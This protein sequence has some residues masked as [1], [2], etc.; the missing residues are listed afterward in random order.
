MTWI[1]VRIRVCQQKIKTPA[2]LRTNH[3]KRTTAKMCAAIFKKKNVVGEKS[4]KKCLWLIIPSDFK[5]I[6]FEHFTFW[7]TWF[8]CSVTHAQ[9][10]QTC[11]ADTISI[12][13]SGARLFFFK[14]NP[15]LSHAMLPSEGSRSDDPNKNTHPRMSA[16]HEDPS[17][18]ANRSWK[19]Q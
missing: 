7:E 13:I 6:S 15:V 5:T 10:A 17:K 4:V 9:Y 8:C 14:K 2:R 16:H 19:E 3:G 11:I 18:T 1:R 12:K